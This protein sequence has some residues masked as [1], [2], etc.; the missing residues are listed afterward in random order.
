MV[1]QARATEAQ[2]RY[3]SALTAP[4]RLSELSTA[5]ARQLIGWLRAGPAN[6]SRAQHCLLWSLIDQLPRERAR[7]LLDELRQGVAAEPGRP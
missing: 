5:E 1:E 6:M 3:L 7:Q 4:D 2:L